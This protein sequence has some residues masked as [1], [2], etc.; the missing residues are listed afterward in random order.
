MI[1]LKVMGM[2]IIFEYCVVVAFEQLS[3]HFLNQ[4][5]A[6][7]RPKQ[8]CCKASARPVQGQHMP[9]FLKL[10]LSGKSVQCMCMSVCASPPTNSGMIWHDMEPT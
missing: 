2:N 4:A 3:H 1:D 9:G 5:S 7:L 10:F 8:D 6:G